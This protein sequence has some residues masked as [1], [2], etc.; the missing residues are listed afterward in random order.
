MSAQEWAR[1][2][3]WKLQNLPRSRRRPPNG[4]G[5]APTKRETAFRALP[6]ATTSPE[7]PPARL[8]VVARKARSAEAS[9]ASRLLGLKIRGLADPPTS[10]EGAIVMLRAIE[11]VARHEPGEDAAY[12]KKVAA[13][14]GYRLKRR[15]P[16]KRDVLELRGLWSHAMRLEREPY[17]FLADALSNLIAWYEER[18]LPRKM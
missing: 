18:G 16:D 12:I 8:D 13:R 15:D 17:H 5:A 2:K 14:L 1:R 4:A 11:N 9:K 3:I 10:Q 7:A 6:A